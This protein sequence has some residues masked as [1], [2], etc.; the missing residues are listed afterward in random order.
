MFALM[1]ATALIFSSC[2]ADQKTVDACAD[3]M[4]SAIEKLDIENDPMSALGFLDE[5]TKIMDK[6]GYDGVT[7]SQLYSAMEKK[8]PE[9]YKK[10]K[11]LV[12][13]GDK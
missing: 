9:G 12:D 8:C 11:E 7:E 1:L 5:M 4:C 2:G 3:D 6:E 13:A 10:F